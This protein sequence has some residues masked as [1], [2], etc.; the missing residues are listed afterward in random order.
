[1]KPDLRPGVSAE[2]VWPVTA[3]RVIALGRDAPVGAVVFS[4]PAMV[5]LM[6]DAARAALDPYLEPGEESVGARVEVEHLA[7][8][9]LGTP[10]TGRAVVTAVEGRLIDFEITARD[11]LEVIGRGVHRR[12]V[13]GTQRFAQRLT[14]KSNRLPGSLMLPLPMMPNT[15]TLPPLATLAVDVQGAVAR[16]TLNRPAKRNAVNRQMTGEWEAVN[17]WLAGHPDVR[18]VILSGAGDG[19][20]AGDDVPEVGELPLA[21]AHSLSL[22]QAR[23]YLAWERLPQVFIAA[24]HGDALG[25]GCVAAYS[26]DFRI[27]A[28]DARFG[29]PEIRLGWPPGYGVAQLTALVGKARA[30]ELCLTGEPVSARAALEFGLVHE[31]VSR[32]RMLPAAMELAD[33]LLALP[34]EALGETKRLIHEDEGAAPKTAHLADTAAYIR[35]LA[36]PDARE[37]IAAFREKRPPRFGR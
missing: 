11:S 35:C 31:V 27:A 15:G 29:M 26:C 12:A 37:G 2:L 14:E 36:L 7:A 9:P 24:V 6:E 28:H 3:E 34:A 18:V 4:T 16:V 23:L 8:T 30:L 20:C 25:A 21:E 13:I 22:R 19:F 17:A 10:V 32:A 5:E 33:K 1:M